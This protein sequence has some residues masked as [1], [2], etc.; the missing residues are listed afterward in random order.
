MPAE[1]WEAS[2]AEK[3]AMGLRLFAGHGVE[4]TGISAIVEAPND[5]FCAYL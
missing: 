4:P 3:A 1:T 5:M 2:A